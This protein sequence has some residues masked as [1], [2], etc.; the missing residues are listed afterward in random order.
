ML[1][2]VIS[3]VCNSAGKVFS[4]LHNKSNIGKARIK[5]A[6]YISQTRHTEGYSRNYDSYNEYNDYVE[7][8]RLDAFEGDES[9]YWN[10]E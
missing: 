2:P 5:Q 1:T 8:S 10:I 6:K 9:N 3:I 7:E 4:L